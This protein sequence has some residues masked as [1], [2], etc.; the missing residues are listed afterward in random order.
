MRFSGPSGFGVTKAIELQ[1]PDR[2]EKE[3]EID[4]AKE[5]EEQVL[6]VV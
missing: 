5:I 6:M 1:D 2:F 3:D 4:F